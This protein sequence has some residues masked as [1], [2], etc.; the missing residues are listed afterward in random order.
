MIHLAK[1]E[2]FFLHPN[3]ND[4]VV[5]V[6]FLCHSIQSFDKFLFH[7]LSSFKQR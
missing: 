1:L 7:G 3:A 6:Q 5:V 2:C 4:F